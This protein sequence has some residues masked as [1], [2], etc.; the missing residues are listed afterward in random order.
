M[1]ETSIESRI[2]LAMRGGEPGDT[3]PAMTTARD[4]AVPSA[5]SSAEAKSGGRRTIPQG[6]AGGDGLGE[7]VAPTLL[8]I[9]LLIIWVTLEPFHDRS[10]AGMI[11]TQG[12]GTLI[13]QLTFPV[14]ALL[15]VGYV[16]RTRPTHYPALFAWL[17]VAVIAWLLIIALHSGEVGTALRRVAFE[18]FCLSIAAS[19]LALPRSQ[20]EFAAVMGSVALF[21]LGLCYF[22]VIALPDLSIHQA[23]DAVERELAGDWRGVYSHKNLAGATMAVFVYVGLFAA[24]AWNRVAGWTI[25]VAA[26]I[27]I[28]FTHSKTTLGLVP[29]V[30][31]VAWGMERSTRTWQRAL[32]TIGVVAFMNLFTVGASWHGP[33]HNIVAKISR[34]PSYTGRTDLWRFSAE[35][36]LQKPVFGYGLGGFWRTPEIMYKDNTDADP[37]K[38]DHWVTELGTD[39]HNSYLETALQIGIPGLV[40]V[41]AWVLVLPLLAYPI[42]MQQPENRLMG[43]LF[44][45]IW[46]Q[47]IFMTALETAFLT[48]NNPVWFMGVVAIF[49]LH[50]LTR[51]RVVA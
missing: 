15:V 30:L 12:A 6:S 43:R 31:L 44:A 47:M 33:I 16:A 22:G 42:A 34:D 3:G 25:V 27:F 26:S 9:V 35:H 24:A 23:T 41:L 29:F 2:A 13:N 49:G 4:A 7:Y 32:M 36:I 39:S 14:L 46:L 11:G 20:R 10:G 8:A 40:L 18:L 50:L 48:R 28:W 1:L 17:Y 45:R 21:T 51:R 5:S 37:D 38:A 19:L